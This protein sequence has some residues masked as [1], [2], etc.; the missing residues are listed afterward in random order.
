VEGLMD[1]VGALTARVEELEKQLEEKGGG[2]SDV[3]L[4]AE[5]PAKEAPRQGNFKS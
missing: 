2:L 5:E 1:R 4:E 3:G